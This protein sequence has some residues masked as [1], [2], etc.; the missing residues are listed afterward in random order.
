MRISSETSFLVS[1]IAVKNGFDL[2]SAPVNDRREVRHGTFVVFAFS[3]QDLPS[4]LDS[5][6]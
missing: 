4:K 5:E 2:G 1:K 6:M 3:L